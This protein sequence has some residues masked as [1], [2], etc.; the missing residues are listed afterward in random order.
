MIRNTNIFII[1]K[2]FNIFIYSTLYTT[3]ITNTQTSTKSYQSKQVN[4]SLSCSA[5][6]VIYQFGTGKAIEDCKLNRESESRTIR[7]AG[8]SGG[9]LVAAAL[10][11]DINIEVVKSELYQIINV[12]C[13]NKPWYSLT[14]LI[15]KL[16]FKK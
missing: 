2:Y 15:A 4:F 12:Y 7:Y 13:R 8:S 3:S 6:G 10:N 11:S 9:T 5:F 14:G 1:C 16:K